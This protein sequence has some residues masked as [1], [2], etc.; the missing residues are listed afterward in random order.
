ML[1]KHLQI[2][3][4]GNTQ[5]PQI[6]AYDKNRQR[7]D[8]LDDYGT[9]ETG[10]SIYPMVSP[11]SLQH[12]TNRQKEFLK[13]FPVNRRKVRHTESRIGGNSVVLLPDN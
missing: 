3:P 8:A 10:T 5:Q 2:G 9:R 4:Y 11:L 13:L 6:I 12:A 7:S 1:F